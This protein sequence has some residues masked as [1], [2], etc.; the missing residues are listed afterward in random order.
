MTAMLIAVCGV[1]TAEVTMPEKMV[2]LNEQEIALLC[3]IHM[4]DGVYTLAKAKSLNDQVTRALLI[5]V[6]VRN[7]WRHNVGSISKMEF[8]RWHA[9]VRGLNPTDRMQQM[10]YCI[11]AG[12]M[13]LEQLSPGDRSV[14][15]SQAAEDMEAALNKWHP[16]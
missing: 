7:E 14:R 6:A 1:A 12:G 5:N 8:Q 16:D 2:L 15:I 3:T 4:G 11:S 13:R 10:N 9:I